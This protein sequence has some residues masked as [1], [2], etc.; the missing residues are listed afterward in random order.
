MPEN[1]HTL[2]VTPAG[3]GTVVPGIAHDERRLKMRMSDRADSPG[4]D[5]SL[6]SSCFI[7]L[8]S[9]LTATIVAIVIVKLPALC[10]PN[11]ILLPIVL[12]AFVPDLSSDIA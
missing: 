4:M 6:S 5:S 10:R 3:R 9:V 1:S 8:A 12:H 2:T 7:S 11:S